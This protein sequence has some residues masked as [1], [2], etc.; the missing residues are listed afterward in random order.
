VRSAIP[1]CSSISFDN[2][3]HG[4]GKGLRYKAVPFG[5]T[6]YGENHQGKVDRMIRWFRL[7]AYQAVQKWGIERLPEPLHAPL[8]ENSQYGY[9]FLHC[10]KPRDD[11][12]DPEA[13]DSRSLPFTSYYVSTKAA[14]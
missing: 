7:T 11:D 8:K 12:Y 13:I 5:E 14:A 9:I 10:V 6:F 1:P 3:W 4:G 2:R